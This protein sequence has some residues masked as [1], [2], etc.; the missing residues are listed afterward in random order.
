MLRSLHI[1]NYA[2]IRQ[3]DIQFVDGFVAITGETGAGKSILLGALSLLLGQRADTSVLADKQRKCVV[4]AQFDIAELNLQ[5]LLDEL[6]IDYDESLIIRREILPS[7]KSRA[8]VNDTPVQ[9]QPL[10]QLGSQLV[11]IHSQHETLTLADSHFQLSLLDTIALPTSSNGSK[12]STPL[13]SYQDSFRSYSSL[14]HQLEQLTAQEAQNRRDADYLQFQFDELLHANLQEEEQS[15]LEEELHRLSHLETVKQQLASVLEACD[16]E[17]DSA[18]HRLSSSRSQLQKAASFDS[19]LQPLSERLDSLCIELRDILSSLSDADADLNFSPERLEQLTERLDLIYHL[20]KKHSVDSVLQ[21]NQLR[22]SLDL[23]LQSMASLDEQIQ[24]TMEQVDLAYGQLQQQAEILT[25]LRHQAALQLEKGILP[26]LAQL[27]MGEACLKV[28]IAPAADFG[29]LG[30]DA[31]RFLFNA[32]RG[33]E[34]REIARVASGGELS[35]LMLAIKSMITRRSLLP[36]IIFDEIDTGVS[37]NISVAVGGIMQSMAQRMQVIAI[38]HLPQIAAKATQH[39]KVAKSVEQDDLSPTTISRIS[40]LSPSDRLTEIA[41]MLSS[42][43]P[44]PAALQTAQ[45]LIQS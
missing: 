15:I 22:D 25:S 10:K 13:S 43:P 29:V 1:E 21:L 40:Q 18:L 23:R 45:E 38:T 3:T 16:G 34:L 8:F 27:G 5:T 9:L 33:G 44:T 12:S 4:E 26:V 7:A 42:N 32:N 30:H 6:D 11:D 20:Q 35:R 19:R 17:N 2:L 37:G 36:T 28:D 24:H 14:K 41:V 31:V 39:L